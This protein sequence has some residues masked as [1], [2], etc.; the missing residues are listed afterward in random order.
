MYAE[1]LERQLH[2]NLEYIK[3]TSKLDRIKYLFSQFF[4]TDDVDTLIERLSLI[5]EIINE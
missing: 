2:I 1:E 5:E 3:S 4:Q